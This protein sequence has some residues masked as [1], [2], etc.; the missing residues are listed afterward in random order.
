VDGTVYSEI[1]RINDFIRA[2]VPNSEANADHALSRISHWWIGSLPR[3][4]W[5]KENFRLNLK[6][7][8]FFRKYKPLALLHIIRTYAFVISRQVVIS[9]G[10]LKP[11]K[12]LRKRLFPGKYF[13]Y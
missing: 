7:Y 12:D 5:T 4:T 13:E 10:L 6:L 9:L 11:A 8:R 2:E 3:Q 1:I